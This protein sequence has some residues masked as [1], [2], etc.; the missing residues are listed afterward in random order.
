MLP[1]QI[2][3]NN[4]LYDLSEVPIPTDRVDDEELAHPRA[5]DMKFVRDFMWTMGPV[6]SLFDFATFYALLAWLD[7]Q[8]ALFQTGWFI[9]SLATQV[10]V[11]FVI[12]TRHRP[13]SSRPGVALASTALLTVAIAAILPLT[14]LGHH[15]GFVSPP[16][17]FYLIL[18]ALTALYLIVA[19]IVKRAFFRWHPLANAQARAACV[20]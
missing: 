17:K 7:A 6:S 16:A 14:P 15:F 12:R 8:E 3:L 1:V 10:L 5:W 9:E 2:L 11:I 19:E 18:A 20:L 13:W 4:M